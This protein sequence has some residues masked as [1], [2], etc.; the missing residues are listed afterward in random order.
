VPRGSGDA[1][2]LADWYPEELKHLPGISKALLVVVHAADARLVS[3]M[4]SLREVVS[5][6]SRS[7]AS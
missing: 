1:C 4:E 6:D 3:V 5:L 2:T 7:K